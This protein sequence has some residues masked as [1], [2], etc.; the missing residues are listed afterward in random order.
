MSKGNGYKPPTIDAARCD[1][2]GDCAV[3]APRIFHQS[4]KQPAVILDPVGGPFK[5]L[6]KA[7]SRCPTRAI[8]PG[9]P[10]EGTDG[11]SKKIIALAE[12]YN[13]A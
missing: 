7:A 3:I 5:R 12:R 9:M 4:G 8:R 13:L 10:A 11:E 1:G 6:V 2:C